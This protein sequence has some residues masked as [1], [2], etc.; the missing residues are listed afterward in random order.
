MNPQM[1]NSKA[2]VYFAY[3]S[4]FIA[5]GATLIG[6]WMTEMTLAM[7]GFM[8]MGVLFLTGSAFTLAKTVRDEHEAKL[9]H[10]RLEE[11]KTEKLLREVEREAA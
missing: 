11:A 7:K 4:F 2:Y 6:A 8:T 1:Q 3:L 5:L 9:F 10:N